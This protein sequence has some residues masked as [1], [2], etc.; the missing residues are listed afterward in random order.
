MKSSRARFALLALPVFLFATNAT[1]FD[2]SSAM[3]SPGVSVSAAQAAFDKREAAY[4]ANNVGVAL[5][6]QYKARE[7]VESFTHALEIKPDLAIAR[8]N[9]AIALYYLPDAEGSKREAEKALK[10]A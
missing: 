8:I 6:E 10:R 5:L 1:L 7:A 2:Y 3:R 9:L 4:R